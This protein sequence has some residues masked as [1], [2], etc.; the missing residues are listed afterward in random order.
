MYRAI[1]A[2][3]GHLQRPTFEGVLHLA[4]RHTGFKL[5][6]YAEWPAAFSFL[7]DSI[8][9]RALAYS[10]V[11]ALKQGAGQ[12]IRLRSNYV[13]LFRRERARGFREFD[14]TCAFCG[15]G[16]HV[17]AEHLHA[18][19]VCPICGQASGGR[20]IGLHDRAQ[21]ETEM[22]LIWK[23]RPWIFAMSWGR[24]PVL[25]RVLAHLQSALG[26]IRFLRLRRR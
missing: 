25:E 11:D 5:V 14:M 13:F 23:R 7:R 19:W 18:P 20:Q 12:D 17:G 21:L 8:A 16:S 1:F 22:K 10:M 26:R 4:Y 15:G 6:T 3:G 2:G 9:M 24:A